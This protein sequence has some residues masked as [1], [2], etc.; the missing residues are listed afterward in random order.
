MKSI[1]TFNTCSFD[2][3]S[4]LIFTHT[5]TRSSPLARP[6]TPVYST[7]FSKKSTFSYPTSPVIISSSELTF[8]LSNLKQKYSLLQLPKKNKSLRKEIAQL[9]YRISDLEAENKQA[10]EEIEALITINKGLGKEMDLQFKPIILES[11]KS[12]SKDEL[13]DDNDSKSSS[14]I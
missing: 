7:T 8:A 6:S 3:F 12:K 13:F 14:E 10:K 11:K 2:Y 4:Y 1:K 5:P 9:R